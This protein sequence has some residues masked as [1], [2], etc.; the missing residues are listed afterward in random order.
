MLAAV[1]LA[2]ATTLVAKPAPISFSIVSP[3]ELRRARTREMLAALKVDEAKR[4]AFRYERRKRMLNHAA[5]E[6]Q[7]I[8]TPSNAI[9]AVTVDFRRGD[10]IV[11][12]AD[13]HRIVQRYTP[14]EA[15]KPKP[16]KKKDGQAK[17]KAD[18]KGN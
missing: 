8:S 12:Y 3:A 9:I 16:A 1:M 10:I 7:R 13:G 11:E 2:V 6:F 17:K 5:A 15:A 4:E 14:P 18:E